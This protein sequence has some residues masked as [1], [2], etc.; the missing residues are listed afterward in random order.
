MN[1]RISE[2]EGRWWN[3]RVDDGRIIRHFQAAFKKVK[4]GLT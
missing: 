2:E 1:G 3:C 4:K